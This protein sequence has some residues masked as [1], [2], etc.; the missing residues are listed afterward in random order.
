MKPD[1]ENGLIYAPADDECGPAMR[2]CT[3][4]ERKFIVALV[5]LGA[6]NATQAAMM[7]GTFTT[8]ESAA[9]SAC[10]WKNN[11]R[12]KNALKEWTQH[13]L[14]GD[15]HLA[16]RAL[17]EIISDPLHKDRF[18]AV[19]ELFN[20]NGMLVETVQRHII[21]DTRDTREIVRAAIDYARS[22]GDAQLAYKL[23]GTSVPKDVI[24]AEFTEVKE[25]V[26]VTVQDDL[27]DLLS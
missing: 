9:V 8:R 22:L 25:T 3:E 10:R 17:R 13:A 26:P 4:N 14:E 1:T 11:E 16:Q 5:E 6:R 15:V 23:L 12:V 7:L 19:Q 27:E 24:D 20:R 18:K 21:E 2:L